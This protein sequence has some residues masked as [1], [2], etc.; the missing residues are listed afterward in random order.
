MKQVLSKI[1][2]VQK[3]NATLNYLTSRPRSEMVGLGL[4]YGAPGLGKTRWAQRTAYAN[5]YHIYLRI[6]AAETQ[7]SFLRKLYTSLQFTYGIPR[8]IKGSKQ[9]FYLESVDILVEAPQTV[10]FI[11]EIDYAFRDKKLLGSIRDLADET[12]A[13]IVL[14][15]MQD[16]KQSLLKANVHY[17]DRCNSFCEFRK[18]T[19]A[20]TALI[21]AEVPEVDLDMEVVNY[22]HGKTKGTL[23]QII[24]AIDH[25]ERIGR[26]KKLK[27]LAM[28]D[29]YDEA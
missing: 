12:L 25:F 8:E 18:L 17:F 19:A 22:I 21:C 10:I 29:L 15:G 2:N 1:E 5:N 3:A 16:A 11:D 9:K 20:D 23:R 13:T 28:K 6:D 4:I 24:K 14:I 27:A 7:R 26:A